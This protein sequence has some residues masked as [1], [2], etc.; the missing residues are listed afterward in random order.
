VPY[1]RPS[2]ATVQQFQQYLLQHGISAF[3]RQS[4]GRDI[5]AACGQLRFEERV[6]PRLTDQSSQA[7][8]PSALRAQGEQDQGGETSRPEATRRERGDNDSCDLSRDL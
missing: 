8:M 3:V 1:R 2:D 4:R 6:T 5:S 7:T